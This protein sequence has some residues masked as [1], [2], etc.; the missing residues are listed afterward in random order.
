MKG[1]SVLKRLTRKT[2][3]VNGVERFF[4]VDPAKDTLAEV[5]RRNG[6]TGTKIGC[7]TGVCGACSVILNGELKR[8][9]TVKI[10]KVEERS[11]ILTIEGIGTPNHLHPL[12]QAWAF[13]GAAQCGFCSPGFIVSAY[14]LL[15]QNPSPTREEVRA[16]FKKNHNICRCTGY[17]QIVDAVMLA[18][19]VMRGE[20]TMDDITYHEDAEK[21]P[22]GTT[23]P[24]PTAISKVCGLTDFG[25]DIGLR[26][27]EGFAHLVV[28]L[29]EVPH[30]KINKIDTEEAEKAP[31]VY[32]VLTAK[33]VKGSNELGFPMFNARKKGNGITNF[34]IIAGKMIN[35]VG[36]IV[37][38]VA[39]DSVEHARAAAKLVKQD[40][41][42]LPYYMTAPEAVAPGAMQLYPDLPNFHTVQPVIKGEDVTELFED[43]PYVAEGSF[44]SQHEPHLPIESDMG[45]AYIDEDGMYT[46][47][48]KSQNLTETIGAT[49]GATGVPKE[50]LRVISNAPGGMFGYGITSPIPAILVTAL[51]NLDMPCSLSMT[52]A[53]FNHTSGKRSASFSNGRIAVDE[54]GKILAVEYDAA[55]DHGAYT[56]VAPMIFNNLVTVPFHGYNI[57]NI[58]GLARGTVSNQSYNTAYRG[59]GSPQIYTTSEAMI[60]MA[61]E[62]AGIDAWQF[63]Y[64][65]CARPGDLT[66]NQRPYKEYLYPMLLE[67]IKPAYDEYKAIAD[68]AKAEGRHV[69]VGMALGGFLA[70]TGAIDSS[71]M[72]IELTPE[73][74]FLVK[75]TWEDVGQGGDIGSLVCTL[76]ALE[77]MGVKADQIILQMNDSKTCPDSGLAAASR[78]HYMTGNATID[79]CTKLMNAMRKEDGTY[80]TYDE[81]VA[82][83]IP[84][85]Y[86]G[87]YD[88]FNLGID[89]GPNPNDG[90]CD[91][92][93]TYMYG[94][95]VC[96]VEVDVNTGK[97]QVQ[98][99]TSWADIGTIGNKLAVL[100]QAYGGLSHA[101]GFALSEDYDPL[102]KKSGNIVGC[103]VPQIDEIP[104]DFNV[105][106]TETP[107]PNGPFGSSG[108]SECF[109]CSAHMAV[110]NAINNACGVRVYALPATPDKVK[111]GWE[112]LQKGED[113]TPPKYFLG[114]DLD[115]EFD[116]IL[117]NPL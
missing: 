42:I 61:A 109:Q 110:I 15:L 27:P 105:F 99:W 111:A 32:K 66:I 108:C 4:I 87:H 106:F 107:R 37:A 7:N 52:Y 22:Y 94:V 43:A 58:R 55:L 114:S 46:I 21:D 67:K 103:G 23:R 18:A 115:D 88:Q 20:K 38:V 57:P 29:S 45:Q 81:M 16:W 104:D 69:G 79:G 98:K 63:R 68:A 60:D 14:A 76:K 73:N 97:S 50:Q 101:I 51:Q 6:L 83:G 80:R 64:D 26:L 13:A 24:R 48:L 31:G 102:S 74:K 59:F 53:E 1:G 93:A 34:P 112:K 3:N 39:A 71:E 113:L 33:D 85:C 91:K 70:T 5:L 41:E 89:I 82:E 10:A 25:D 77:P 100:G 116:E 54:N 92:D 28:V 86:I 90:S 35:K 8:A 78:Q 117:A 62:K 84:T 56:G 72:S 36:D 11:E 49:S 96:L 17:K 40:L 95:H 2:L 30:A 47:Q 75:N 44:A 65:N 19:A 12:Q 9:C